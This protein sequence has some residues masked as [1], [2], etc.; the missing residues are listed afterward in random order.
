MNPL[1]IDPNWLLDK[2]GGVA[3]AL[4]IFAVGWMLSRTA[5]RI[6]HRALPVRRFDAALAGFL[7][8]GVRYTVLAAAVIAALDTVGI[9]TTSLAAVLASAGVAVGLALQGSLSNFA[10]GVLILIL[11]PFD[12]GQ[13]VTVS[14]QTGT[15]TD[16]GLFATTLTGPGNEQIIIPNAQVTSNV[17][18]NFTAQAHRRGSVQVG[19][20]YGTDVARV[21]EVLLNAAS[22]VKR[23]LQEPAPF[24]RFTGLGASSLDF[25][26]FAYARR[27]DLAVMVHELRRAVYED[28][29][30]AGI[31]IPYG[32][33]VVHHAPAPAAQTAVEVAD[34]A[35]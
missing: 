13:T 26:L 30:A 35:S 22:R 6:V 19:V 4:V 18:V 9:H 16:I 11:R 14:G 17:I 34:R 2:L 3:L 10:S 20:A 28:L 1:A 7:A 32:Q 8:N 33:I 25:E 23:V 29:Q 12:I 21:E 24:V 27:E 15:V 31:E 5:H